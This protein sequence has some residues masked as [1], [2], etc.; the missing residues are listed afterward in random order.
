MI[1]L[2]AWTTPNG[3]K[4]SVM[5]EEA[6][7][8]YRVHRVDIGKGEQF[9]ADF[10]KISPNN[11]IP[12]I[13]DQDAAGGPLSI[14]ESGAILIHLADR[15]GRFL[16]AEG[17]ARS[18]TLQWLFW[19]VGGFGPMLGQY[20]H[21]AHRAERGEEP[22]DSYALSRFRDEAVRLFRVLETRLAASRYVG[23]EAIS[24]ADFAVYPWSV[25]VRDKLEAD[26]GAHHPGVA[27]WEAELALRPALSRGM[28][29]LA[30]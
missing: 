27:R 16:A 7:L 15:A 29:S 10:L 22:A 8:D 6:Q 9:A 13:I 26:T 1:D 30:S 23:G 5:L 3:R 25:Y 17:R 21:F 12:A 20:R 24:I 11:K 18:E 2:Y 14:F 19:Q 28:A 4:I